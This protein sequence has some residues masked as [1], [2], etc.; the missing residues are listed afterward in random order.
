MSV[1]QKLDLESAQATQRLDV[2]S[3][4]Q[5]QKLDE[6]MLQPHQRKSGRSMSLARKVL[7]TVGNL[8]MM[9]GLYLLLFVG[10]LMADEQFN[11]YAASGATDIELPP[12]AAVAPAPP[13]AAEP[14]TTVQQPAPAASVTTSTVAAVGASTALPAAPRTGPSRVSIPALNNG[15]S[16]LTNI[17]PSKIFSNEP[18]T[19]TR[20]VIPQLNKLDKKVVEVGYAVQQAENGQNIAVWDVDKYRV[21]HHHGTSNPGGGGNIVLAGHSGGTA[22]PF[23]DIYY[24]QAGDVIQLYS[25][26]QLYDYTVTEVVVVDEDGQSLEKRLENARY[27]QSTDEEVVTM[28]TCWPLS[29]QPGIKKFTQRVI[30]RA[31][32]ATPQVTVAQPSMDAQEASSWLAR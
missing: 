11:V 18:S 31:E 29:D 20:I 6:H 3:A 30:V 27:I 2:S 13:A 1:T 17:V 24:L 26:G 23:N 15:G 16:E 5:T 8:V 10:G 7:W 9:A 22:Y 19:I 32:P 21:G 28:V 12:V 14:A 25:D 4:Y